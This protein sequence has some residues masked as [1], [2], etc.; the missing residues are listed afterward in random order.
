MGMIRQRDNAAGLAPPLWTILAFASSVAAGLIVAKV[1]SAVPAPRDLTFIVVGL[2]VAGMGFLQPR[3]AIAATVFAF[4]FSGLLRR[5]FPSATPSADI[6]AIVPFIVALPVAVQGFRRR[7]PLNVSLLLIW[8]TLMAARSLG[9]PL[10]SAAGWMNLTIPLAGAFG[11]QRIDRGPAILVRSLIWCAALAA[12]YGVIQYL[13]PISWDVAW[14]SQSGLASAGVIG[15]SNFRPFATYA[16]PTTGAVVSAIVI[17]IL[18]YKKDGDT[19]R[20]LKIFAISSCSVLVLLSQ[21]RVVWVAFAGTLLIGAFTS[22]RHRL[23]RILVPTVVVVAFL[24]LA[25]QGRVVL[26]RFRTFTNLS[27]DQSVSDRRGLLAQTANLT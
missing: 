5:I 15:K 24:T 21:V 16:A 13:V 7:K 4:V 20:A 25:P 8:L 26:N 22:K 2:A 19:P 11:I 14:L 3:F 27:N 23:R 1:V 17:L 18:M 9:S 10:V 12:T 6:S